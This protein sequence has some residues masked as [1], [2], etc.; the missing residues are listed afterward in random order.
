MPRLKLL[1]ISSVA[2]LAACSQV[3]ASSSHSTVT[4][5]GGFEVKQMAPAAAS[6]LFVKPSS[7]GVAPQV[8]PTPAPPR[9]PSTT[10]PAQQSPAGDRC[11][12]G[13]GVPHKPQPAC[14]PA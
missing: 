8:A 4:N 5:P 14:V 2:V 1:L 3:P 13:T 6:P 12:T 11:S 7:H 9:Q 10:A